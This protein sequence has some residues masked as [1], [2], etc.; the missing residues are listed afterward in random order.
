LDFT[1]ELPYIEQIV[2]ES[3]LLLLVIDDTVGITAKEQHI[4][5]LI[6]KEEKQVATILVVN[7]LDVKWK[8]RETELALVEYYSLGI[9]KVI[10]ISAKVERNLSEIQDQIIL[11]CKAEKEKFSEQQT[12]LDKIPSIL[13]KS[14]LP[15]FPVPQYC[16]TG[17]STKGGNERGQ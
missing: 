16:G 2:K 3:D 9:E 13:T 1:D 11:F 14:P 17:R 6:R 7:K 10:G 5:E 4:L 15:P 8:E 12:N